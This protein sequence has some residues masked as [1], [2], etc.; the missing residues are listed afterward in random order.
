MKQKL[1]NGEKIKLREM[2]SDDLDLIHDWENRPELWYLGDVHEPLSKAD[3]HDFME[4]MTGDIYLDGQLRLIIEDREANAV[5]CIDLF[6]F[7]TYNEKVGVGILIAEKEDRRKGYAKEAL[8]LLCNYCFEVLNL[9][10]LYCH[11]TVDNE[12]SIRLFSD[13]GFIESGRCKDWVKKG[14]KFIDAVFM[15][16]LREG[17][18]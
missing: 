1:L 3:I 6:E 13:R 16:K 7:D 14:K 10:Q 5:G 12:G 15:Q 17:N 4:G 11:I 9:Q 2:G 18:G 8:M